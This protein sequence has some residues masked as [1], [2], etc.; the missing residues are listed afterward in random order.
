MIE[1]TSPMSGKILEIQVKVGDSI[2]E[3]DEVV[4][5]EAMKMEIPVVSPADG[6]VKEIK[7]AVEDSVEAD[8][9]LMVLE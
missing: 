7:V 9:V 1:I 3:D 4:I 2:A 8:Q 6:T 5:L